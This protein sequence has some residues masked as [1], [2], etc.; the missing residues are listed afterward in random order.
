MLEKIAQEKLENV[1]C[2][3]KESR[4]KIQIQGGLG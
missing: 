3:K 2:S 4:S 1:D